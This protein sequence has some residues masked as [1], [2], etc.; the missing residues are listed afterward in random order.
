MRTYS[1]HPGALPTYLHLAQVLGRP[2]RGNDFG[3]CCGYWIAQTGRLDQV[4]HLWS[5][6][7]LDERTRLR[8]ILMQNDRWTKE[9]GGAVLPLLQR[10]D[11]RLLGPVRPMSAPETGGLFELRLH[12]ARP[13][14]AKP[15]LDEALSREEADTASS[16]RTVGLWT[17]ISPQPNEVVQLLSFSSCDD[18]LRDRAAHQLPRAE[19]SSEQAQE[20]KLV[21]VES[22]LLKPTLFSPMQ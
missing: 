6:D 14:H 11:I 20:S 16:S 22:I 19:G 9:Y 3:I 17:G 2:V 10:Q 8:A 15:W 1:F 12:R 4:W 7:S 13:G 21:E 18:W 5:Y